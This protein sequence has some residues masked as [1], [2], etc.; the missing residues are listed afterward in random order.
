MKYQQ[1]CIPETFFLGD[2]N[3]CFQQLF[4]DD[5]TLSLFFTFEMPI[6]ITPLFTQKI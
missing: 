4:L 5:I 6:I 1:F 3:N 2:P